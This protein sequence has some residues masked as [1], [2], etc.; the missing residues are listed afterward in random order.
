MIQD[1]NVSTI[2]ASLRGLDQKT[3][4][5]SLVLKQHYVTTM[6]EIIAPRYNRFTRAFSFGMDAVWKN[7]LVEL[8][9]PHVTEKARPLPT[10]CSMLISSWA[11]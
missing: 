10:P 6:F 2:P 4:L 11:I 3:H 9:K 1:Q 7:Q 5:D 8:A